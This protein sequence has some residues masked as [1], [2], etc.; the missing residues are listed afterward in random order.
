MVTITT[1]YYK[2]EVS[3]PIQK[4]V[5]CH[6]AFC[7]THCPWRTL[8][9]PHQAICGTIS[10]GSWWVPYQTNW[11]F[12]CLGPD[13]VSCHVNCSPGGAPHQAST[14]LTVPALQ[15]HVSPSVWAQ[16]RRQT[17]PS[18]VPTALPGVENHAMLHSPSQVN[19]QTKPSICSPYTTIRQVFSTDGQPRTMQAPARR[20]YT[21]V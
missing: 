4:A 2:I 14:V 17:R 1:V 15:S 13:S 3:C 10:C 16:R 20:K 9:V 18:T 8:W 19:C 12:S 6:P 11:F 5:S 7:G 21:P